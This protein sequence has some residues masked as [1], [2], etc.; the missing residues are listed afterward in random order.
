[1]LAGASET[2]RTASILI[3]SLVVLPLAA[4]GVMLFRHANQVRAVTEARIAEEV[5]QENRTF[6]G[7]FVIG[8]E[9]ARHAECAN[10]LMD[11]RKRH[12]ERIAGDMIGVL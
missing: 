3:G 2:N 5:A 6:C 12:Q 11:I 10:D 1:M 7:K 9:T 4:F 8:P